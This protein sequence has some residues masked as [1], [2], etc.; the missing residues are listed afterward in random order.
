MSIRFITSRA[1]YN[2]RKGLL[3]ICF[4]YQF[5]P[6]KTDKHGR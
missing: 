6:A 3:A 5:Y 2:H 1:I 4:K